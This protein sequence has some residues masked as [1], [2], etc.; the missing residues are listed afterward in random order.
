MAAA[1]AD[2]PRVHGSGGVYC[3]GEWISIED[4]GAWL[5]G[6]ACGGEECKECPAT[7]GGA[8][9]A[10]SNKPGG[11]AHALACATSFSAARPDGTYDVA[12]VGAGCVGGSVARE[13]ARRAYSVV[14]LEVCGV[15]CLLLLLPLLI[16]ILLILTRAATPV[17]SPA[18]SSSCSR[19]R[20][21]RDAGRDQ[22]QLGH[23]ARGL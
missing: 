7:D 23:R 20:G 12:I 21:R 5:A 8:L 1:K 22:G 2:K 6:G 19:A 10:E 16:L 4:C 14:V 3:G 11:R 15:W 9:R 13:L 18:H 17:P